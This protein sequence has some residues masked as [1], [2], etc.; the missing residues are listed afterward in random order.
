MVQM[1]GSDEQRRERTSVR[2]RVAQEL[3]PQMRRTGVRGPDGVFGR[4][5]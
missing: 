4:T 5:P 3:T 1:Q 2:D